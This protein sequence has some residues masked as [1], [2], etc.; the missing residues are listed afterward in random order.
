MARESR[1]REGRYLFPA[2]AIRG[3]RRT[4]GCHFSRDPEKSLEHV[5]IRAERSAPITLIYR[6]NAGLFHFRPYE[7]S[8]RD[9]AGQLVISS[10]RIA[11]EVI[12]F[13]FVKLYLIYSFLRWQII[14]KSKKKQALH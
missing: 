12:T 5:F 3:K 7:M 6:K 4:R 14:E 13:F 1:K 8:E 11:E 10:T 2:G 9:A